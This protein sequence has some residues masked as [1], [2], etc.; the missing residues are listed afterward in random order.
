MA[1][2]ASADA[3][4]KVRIALFASV[5]DAGIYAAIEKGF[6]RELGID[7]ELVQLDSASIVNTALASGDVD[8]AGAS[9]GAGMYNAV[10][11]GIPL[12]LVADKGK[13]LPGHGYLAL[14]VRK[15]VAGQ[16][17]TLADLRGRNVAVTSYNTGGSNEVFVSHMLEKAGLKLDDI[18]FVN[19][20]FGDIVSALATGRVDVG[21]LVEPLVTSVVSKGIA[22][23]LMRSDQIYPNQQFT[24]IVYGP[25]M[26]KRPDAAKRFMVAYLQGVRFYNAALANRASPSWTE[27]VAILAKHTAVKDPEVYKNMIFP[28]LDSNGRLIEAD[29]KSDISR[30]MASGSMKVVPDLSEALDSSFVDYAITKLGAAK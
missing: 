23:V 12:K 18:N 7:A 19:I 16:I 1:G 29:L 28:G 10:R 11:Q 15:E 2:M 9:L 30:L 13:A 6:F 21:F 5:A 25:G 4:D 8:V 22:D 24:A 14:V 17:K 27:L 26:T 3:A 20:S